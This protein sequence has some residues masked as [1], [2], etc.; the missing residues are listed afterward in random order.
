M[1]LY[2][3]Q[4]ELYTLT[5]RYFQGAS[6]VWAQSGLVKGKRPLVTLQTGTVT[7]PIQ[8]IV[9]TVNGVPRSQYPSRVIWE[10]NLLTGGKPEAGEF[11]KG[12]YTVPHVNTAVNDLLDF[13]NYLNSPL[14][15]GW[16]FKKDIAILSMNGVLDMTA[17]LDDVEWEY[18]A[19]T[20]LTVDFI[21]TAVGAAGILPE[22]P[23]EGSGSDEGENDSK[24]ENPPDWTQTASGGGSQEL[25][26]EITGWFEE[27][28]TEQ[29][30]FPT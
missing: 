6:V 24:P 11:D 22:I 19:M 28:E 9:E 27:V 18:R 15:T 8:P 17:L 26:E 30:E 21:Q 12:T 5:I 13:I 1:T 20:E 25:A 4:K 2:E 14:V 3:L 7:R 29:E 23:S 10:I 16:C